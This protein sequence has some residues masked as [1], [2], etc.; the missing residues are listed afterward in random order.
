LFLGGLFVA[1]VQ[2]NRIVGMVI[3]LALACDSDDRAKFVK[4]DS[5]RLGD[6]R[7]RYGESR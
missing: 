4:A 3:G 5:F 2:Y 1:D 7:D 6:A